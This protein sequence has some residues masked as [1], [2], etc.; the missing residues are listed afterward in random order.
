[1][2]MDKYSEM[3]MN[4][5]NIYNDKSK[6]REYA[7]E[8]KKLRE[9]E[10][11]DY[12]CLNIIQVDYYLSLISSDD[13]CLKRIKG[14]LLN[15]KW[16]LNNNNDKIWHE[17]FEMVDTVMCHDKIRKNIYD[18]IIDDENISEVNYKEFLLFRNMLCMIYNCIS[19]SMT[20][21]IMIHNNFNIERANL[22]FYGHSKK[23]NKLYQEMFFIRVIANIKMLEIISRKET[24][25]EK[26]Y[27]M[28]SHVAMI[29]EEMG[30][31]TKRN[32]IRLNSYIDDMGLDKFNSLIVKRLIR[33]KEKE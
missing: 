4:L 19:N 1:M 21:E 29:E 5:K 23:I 24:C 33:R 28:F 22:E 30:H 12:D 11:L 9:I 25:Q 32:L 26:R 10:K 3:L 18:M 2:I 17:E 16:I 14:L 31:L 13:L 7:L 27:L 8:I 15:K 20:E 6:L